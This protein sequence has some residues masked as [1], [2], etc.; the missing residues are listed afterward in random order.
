M[1][2][3][4][5]FSSMGS[6]AEQASKQTGIPTPVILAQ[7]ADESN[8]GKSDLSQ[9]ANNFAGIKWNQNSVA[10]GKT[11]DLGY[12]NYSDPEQFTQDYVRVM[13][14]PYYDSVRAAGSVD[15]AISALAK[16]PWAESGYDGGNILSN[17]INQN[18]LGSATYTAAAAGSASGGLSNLLGG[19]DQK[20]NLG[21]SGIDNNSTDNGVIDMKLDGTVV[22]NWNG[23]MG[24]TQIAGL[25]L[26]GIT[27]VP[28][29]SITKAEGKTIEWQEESKTVLVK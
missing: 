13:S 2:N 20:K 15:G 18:G 9:R 17:I 8:Y 6:Y 23:S 27:Y 21:G 7:W 5:F 11:G 24:Q 29:R 4:D 22:V 3:S 25:L 12:A 26:D 19:V 10:S 1:P 16:S 28:V 14:L